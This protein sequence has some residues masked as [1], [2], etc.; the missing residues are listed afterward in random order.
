MIHG[1]D[2]LRASKSTVDEYYEEQAKWKQ[3][4]ADHAVQFVPAVSPG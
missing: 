2:I 1:R 3:L 4:A